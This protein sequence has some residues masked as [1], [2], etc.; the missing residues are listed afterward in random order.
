MC[1]QILRYQSLQMLLQQSSSFKSRIDCSMSQIPNTFLPR[2]QDSAEAIKWTVL[3][4]SFR[5]SCGI[6][7]RLKL[8]GRA[9][10]DSPR[11]TAVRGF[12]VMTAGVAG[13]YQDFVS[14]GHVKYLPTYRL[15]HDYIELTFN[16]I[17]SRGRWNNN[18]T[19]NQFQAVFKKLLMKHEIKPTETGNI[20]SQDSITILPLVSI[21][22]S[23]ESVVLKFCSA[24]DPTRTVFKDFMTISL[25][26]TKLVMLSSAAT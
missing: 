7:C 25:W 22:T 10:H 20:V 26:L 11:K 12:M 13:L 8:Q 9:L 14:T 18:P 5:G 24:V 6:H 16:F 15:R 4:S 23:R 3:A 17:R 2:I 19:P 21:V 1:P